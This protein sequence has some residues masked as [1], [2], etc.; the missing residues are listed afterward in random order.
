[1]KELVMAEFQLIAGTLMFGTIQTQTE[2][3]A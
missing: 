2:K 1:M 3:E